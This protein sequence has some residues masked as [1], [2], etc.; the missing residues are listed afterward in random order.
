MEWLTA[1]LN[2]AAQEVGLGGLLEL[3]YLEAVV[4]G[5]ERKGLEA[6]GLALG[7]SASSQIG[8]GRSANLGAA[9]H[10]SFICI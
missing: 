8:A 1:S 6:C 2:H 4:L 3:A 7:G 10:L 9:A 5:V